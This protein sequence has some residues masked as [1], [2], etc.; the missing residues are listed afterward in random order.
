MKKAPRSSFQ[1]RTRFLRVFPAPAP[2]KGETLPPSARPRAALTWLGA[3]VGSGSL[4]ARDP[5][6]AP[7]CALAPALRRGGP[8]GAARA[9]AAPPGPE[10]AAEGRWDPGVGAG[11]RGAG[12]LEGKRTARAPA[13]QTG[14]R[15]GRG[16][17]GRGERGGEARGRGAAERGRAAGP[18]GS[19]RRGGRPRAGCAERWASPHP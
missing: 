10:A 12:R 19:L 6:R 15:R 5:A 7:G 8:G 1:S 14:G 2:N 18:R 3:A 16:E 9:R 4:R 11:Q 13:E 17:A